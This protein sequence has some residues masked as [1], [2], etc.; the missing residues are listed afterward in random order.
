MIDVNNIPGYKATW[1]GIVRIAFWVALFL[2]AASIYLPSAPENTPFEASPHNPRLRLTATI[3]EDPRF[4]LKLPRQEGVNIAWITDSSGAIF[5]P[6]KFVAEADYKDTKLIPSLVLDRLQKMGKQKDIG[7]DLNI[8]PGL[9]ALENYSSAAAAIESKPDAIV[10]SFNP[11][12]LMNGYEIHKR[13]AHLNRASAL[14]AE[15]PP[16]WPWLVTMASPANN[17]WSALGRKYAIISDMGLYKGRIEALL[18]HIAPQPAAEPAG[19]KVQLIKSNVVFWACFGTLKE[20]CTKIIHPSGKGL[21]NR[22]WYREMLKLSDMNSMGLA[23]DIWQ[24]TIDMLIHSGIPS[25]I[26]MMPV[27]PDVKGDAAAY[28]K[29]QDFEAFLQDYAKRYEGTNIHIT[30]RIPADIQKSIKFRPDDSA[31]VITPGKLDYYLAQQIWPIINSPK[32]R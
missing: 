14:W 3:A 26:Y 27:G 5:P 15:H 31:H 13:R 9:R 19:D 29:L 23:A 6:D 21:D 4:V 24:K 2:T 18:P 28:D 20:D 1:W 11:F 8:Q 7:I 22:L 17:L 32:G 30:P 25:Y 16:A 12:W 10:M